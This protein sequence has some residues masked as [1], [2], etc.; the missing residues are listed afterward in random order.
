MRAYI[1][2]LAVLF[3]LVHGFQESYC[4]D[5]LIYGFNGSK[6]HVQNIAYIGAAL[7]THGHSVDVLTFS[8]DLY[9]NVYTELGIHTLKPVVINYVNKDFLSD[10]YDNDLAHAQV[11]R[12]LR[13]S[14][15][16]YCDAVLHHKS[17]VRES[18]RDYNIAVIDSLCRCCRMLL[19]YMGI[20]YV[21]IHTASDVE[22]ITDV[23]APISYYP[24]QWTT[25][26][27]TDEMT[28]LARFQN[29]LAS[30]LPNIIDNTA[31]VTL[32]HK[33]DITPERHRFEQA[34]LHLM[35]TDVAIGYVHPLVPNVIP[36]GLLTAK[37]ANKLPTDL[38]DFMQ[39]SGDEGVIVVA[40]GTFI[41]FLPSKTLDIILSTIARFPN[42]IIFSYSGSTPRHV[43]DNIKIVKWFNQNDVLAHPKTRLFITHGG[44][45]SY[46]EAMYH[47]VPMVCIPLL[48]DQF[49]TAAKIK[50][51]GV[52][53]YVKMKSLN[54]DNLYE[55]IVEV[56]LNEKYSKRA[57]QLSADLKDVPMNAAGTAV[58]WIEHV[59]K[60]G[61]SHLTVHRNHLSVTEYYLLDVTAVIVT[62]MC[63]TGWSLRRLV[64]MLVRGITC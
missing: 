64:F 10:Y 21:V 31:F 24:V 7:M 34:I 5:I 20:P 14:Y 9:N 49:D 15:A 42:K 58:F 18:L 23:T 50:S 38:E 61:A 51:E 17:Y 29:L 22:C 1:Q 60:Y 8:T 43:G 2:T 32:Y 45:G 26:M 39:N 53:T 59:I 33:H 19:Q 25:M 12:K 47:G 62:I 48:F 11:F 57:K 6:S 27:L 55:A 40:L 28:F 46:G 13:E 63:I 16:S 56:L 3:V 36:I 44:L 52:G 35:V 41:T 30:M 54:Y 37:P 4:A